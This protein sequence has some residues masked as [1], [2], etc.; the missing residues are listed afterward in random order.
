MIRNF[1]EAYYMTA[2]CTEN[3]IN[4]SVIVEES[5][6]ENTLLTEG[7]RMYRRKD[8]LLRE[9]VTTPY[10]G[11]ALKYLNKNL[12]HSMKNVIPSKDLEDDEEVQIYEETKDKFEQEELNDFIIKLKD[13]LRM[14]DEISHAKAKDS[15]SSL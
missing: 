8:I 3:I 14:P 4:G 5:T 6:F 13:F 12:V 15:Y 11:N 10:I 2:I 7:L 9:S 1:I